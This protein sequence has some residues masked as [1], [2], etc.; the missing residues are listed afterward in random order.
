MRFFKGI[1]QCLSHMYADNH[2]DPL[3]SRHIFRSALDNRFKTASKT[4]RDRPFRAI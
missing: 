3:A 2:R 4:F 1:K